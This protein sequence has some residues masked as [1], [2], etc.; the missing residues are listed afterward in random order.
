MTRIPKNRIVVELSWG[1][2]PKVKLLLSITFALS[3]N[4]SVEYVR[5]STNIPQELEIY[6]VPC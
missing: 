1:I 2:E 3:V 5:I 6:L 4:V